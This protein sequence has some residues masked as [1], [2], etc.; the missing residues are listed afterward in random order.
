MQP[1]AAT[2]P[3]GKTSPDVKF[4][5]DTA[6]NLLVVRVQDASGAVQSAELSLR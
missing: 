6:R 4:S 3:E 5:V 2:A 1:G